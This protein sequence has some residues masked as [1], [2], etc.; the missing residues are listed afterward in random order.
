MLKYLFAR[1]AF[2]MNPRKVKEYFIYYGLVPAKYMPRASDEHRRRP[3]LVFMQ[4]K[5]YAY[6]FFAAHR[7]L[8]SLNHAFWLSNENYPLKYSSYF[9]LNLIIKI[10]KT[11]LASP[12]ARLSNQDIN[13]LNR[14]VFCSSW[15][16]L[17]EEDAR[18]RYQAHYQ[19]KELPKSGS[20]VLDQEKEKYYL[21]YGETTQAYTAF[22][23]SRK[24][25]PEESTFSLN[26]RTFLPQ[27]DSSLTLQKKDSIRLFDD[28]PVSTLLEILRK[29]KSYLESM[30]QNDENHLLTLNLGDIITFMENEEEVQGVVIPADNEKAFVIDNVQSSL[31]LDYH[32]IKP[33]TP[34]Q[35]TGSMDSKKLLSLLE[36]YHDHH[37]NL[38]RDINQEITKAYKKLFCST[39]PQ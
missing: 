26:G 21:V 33:T 7:T 35:K 23:L 31:C 37:Q 15:E 5:T 8:R 18:M 39:F 29:R 28:I 22:E 38:D 32:V 2:F 24:S 12:I 13:L 20:I 4:N 9:Q 11:D 30:K 19:T 27:I 1:E 10:K 25:R 14:K 34:F 17:W 3:I 36:R 6:G 16:T